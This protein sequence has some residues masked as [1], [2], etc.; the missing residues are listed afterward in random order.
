MT[1]ERQRVDEAADNLQG[2]WPRRLLQQ[3]ERLAQRGEVLD[4]R[5]EALR[6]EAA[7]L[8]TEYREREREHWTILLCAW[9]IFGAVVLVAMAATP[10]F[11]QWADWVWQNTA[12]RR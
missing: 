3:Q 11:L 6:A 5:E 4:K 1:E 10:A 8:A 2:S 12:W 9:V 7:L